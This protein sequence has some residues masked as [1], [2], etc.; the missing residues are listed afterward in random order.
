[1][2]D[3]TK[4]MIRERLTRLGTLTER[5]EISET[6][7]EISGAPYKLYKERNTNEFLIHIMVIDLAELGR[8]RTGTRPRS[9]H[10][11]QRTISKTIE[12]FM[13]ERDDHDEALNLLLIKIDELLDQRRQ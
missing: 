6:F 4:N 5:E 10:V 9:T 11:P 3:E 2:P 1:M 13:E 8:I 12:E 7:A